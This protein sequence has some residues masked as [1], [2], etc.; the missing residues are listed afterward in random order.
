MQT[1]FYTYTQLNIK[2]EDN[3]SEEMDVKTAIP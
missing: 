3:V 1:L 2:R